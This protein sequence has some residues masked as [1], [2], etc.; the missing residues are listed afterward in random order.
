MTKVEYDES[1]AGPYNYLNSLDLMPYIVKFKGKDV[2]DLMEELNKIFPYQD[3]FSETLL[4]C[5]SRIEFVDYLNKRYNLKI[6]E[7][8]VEHYYI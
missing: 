5:I 2:W 3:K 8:V 4:D 7:Y 1:L 6:Q